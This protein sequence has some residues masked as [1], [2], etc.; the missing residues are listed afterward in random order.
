MN[1]T[2]YVEAARRIA[3]RAMNEG[4]LKPAERITYAFRLAVS[5]KPTDAELKV[6]VEGFNVHLGTYFNEPESAD[7]F[8]TIG[9]SKRNPNLDARELAAYTTVASVILNMDQTITRE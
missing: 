9:D 4:G 3:E 6:L 7:K 5:R 2:I 8:T 1:D